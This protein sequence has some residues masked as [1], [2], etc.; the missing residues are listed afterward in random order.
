MRN[1]PVQCVT[2]R[3]LKT[4]RNLLSGPRRRLPSRTGSLV[5]LLVE[6]LEHRLTPSNIITTIAGNGSGG[7]SGD[8]GS[9]TA[10]M[11]YIPFGVAVDGSGNVFIADTYN[12]RIREVVKATGIIS[13]LAGTSS[14][15]YSGDGGPAIYAQLAYPHGVAVDSSGNVYI[16]DSFNDRIREIVKA[17]GNIITV[18]GNGSIGSGGDGGPATSAQLNYPFAA[19]VDASGNL[20]FADQGNNRIRE[21][22]KATGIIT[23]I[24]GNGTSGYSGDGGPATAAMLNQPTGVAVDSSGNVYIAD[25]HNNRIRE[26]VKATGIISTIAGTGTAGSSGDGGPATSAQLN[27]PNGV[28]VDG[29]GNVFIGDSSNNRIREVVKATGTLITFAGNGTVGFSGDGGPATS[30]Q[31]NYPN[32]VAVDSSGNVYFTDTY[33]YRIREVLG[34]SSPYLGTLSATAWTVNQPGYSGTISITGGT[35]PYS[36]LTATGLPTGLTASLAGATIT[37]SGTPTATGIFNNINISIQDSTGASA[38]RTFSITINAAPALGALTPTQWT[39]GVSGYTGAIPISGGTGPLT[40]SAQANL[41]TGLTATVTGTNVT[42]SGT[43]TTVG[44]YNNVQ[45]TVRDATGVTASG[46]YSITINTP[47][48]GSIITFAGTGTSGYNGDGGPATA[49]TLYYPWSVAVDGSGN[50]FI[51]DFYNSRVRE[52]VKATGN[53]IT[54]AGNGSVGYSGDG[55][56][57]TA[58]KLYYPSGVAVDAS[59]NVYIADLYNNRIREVVKATGVIITIAGSGSTTD[60]GDG[61]PATAAGIASPRGV[62]VDGSGNVFIADTSGNRI[63]EVVKATGIIMTIAGTGTTGYSGDGGPATAAL[64]NYPNG[65]AV[66]ASGNIFI[67]DSNNERLREIVQATG[68]IITVAGNGSVGYGGDGGPATAAKLYNPYSV[69]VDASGNLF[70]ADAY[71]YRIREVVQA[72]GNITT[73]AG[74]GTAGFGGDGGPAT[75]AKLY[76]DYGVA[77][78]GS[79]N[80]FI[81]DAYNN[82]VREVVGNSSP[83]L[84]SLSSTVWTVNQA[85]FSGT[86]GITNG[87]SPYS[88]LIASNLPPGLTASLSG[89]TIT[90]SGTPTATG[91]FSNI[92]ISIQDANGNSGSRTFTITINAAPA[93]GTLTPTQWTVGQ[94]GY[95]GAIPI[96]G[97]TGPLTVS[98]QA[99]LPP[100]L[101]A[102]VS[103]ANVTF[104][105]TPT[106]AGTYSNLQLTVKDAAGATST[107]TFSITVNGAPTL[108]SLSSAAWTV[109]QAGFTGTIAITGGTGPFG[110]LTATGLPPG[111]SAALGGSTITLSGKPTA[112]GTF[113]GITASVKDS[114]GATTSRTFTITINAA[115]ALGA[116]SPTVW[117]VNQPGYSGAIPVS[118]GTGPL[119]VSAQANLPPGLAATVTGTSVTFTGTPTTAGTYSNVQLTVKDAA[120][121]TASG[122]FAITINAVPPITTVAGNG[123]SGYGGDG[124]PATAAQLYGPSGVGVDGSGNLFIADSSNNVIREVVKATGTILT[125][126]GTGT[127]GY[128]GDGGPATAA[129]LYSPSGVAVDG[130]GNVFIADSGN[131]VI[132]EVVKATGTII[133]VAGSGTSGYSGDGGPATAALLN[134]PSG[135]ALDG[136]GNLFIADSSNNV[137]REVVKATG[138]ISTVAGTGTAG[139]GGDGGPATAALLSTPSGVAVDGSGNLFIAD[140]SNYRIREVVQATGN[141]VTVAGT[142]SAGDGGDGGPATAAMLNAPNRVTVDGSGNLFIADTLNN[143][144]REVVKATGNILTAAGN[145]TQGYGGDGGPATAAQLSTPSGLTVD[146]SGNLF[147][148]DQGN[149]RIREVLGNPTP[150]LGSLSPT[151]WTVNQ[152]GFTGT[153]SISGG[154]APY[155]NLTATGLPPG[156]TASL[157]GT[158]ITLS[159]TPTAAGTF[160]AINVAVQDATGAIANAGFSITINPALALGTLAPA[161]WTVGQPGYPGAIPVSGGTGPLTLS[162]QANLPPGLTATLTGTTVT[163]TGTPTTAGTYSNVQLTVKDATG[164]TASGTFTI[165]INAPV[166]NITTIAGNGSQGYSGDNGPATSAMLYHPFGVAVDASGNV[167]FADQSNNRVREVVKATGTIITVA[168]T[169]TAGFSGDGGPATAA[170]LNTPYG[171]AVDASGNLFIADG[172]NN[173]IRE[174]VKATGTIITVAGSGAGGYGGDGGPATSAMLFDAFGVAVDG[175]GNIFIA[176]YANERIREVVQATGIIITIAGNGTQGYGGDGGPA[177]SAMLSGPFGLAVDASGNVFFTDTYNQRIREVVKATGTIVTVAG[178]GTSGYGGDGGPATAAKLAYPEG[179]ALDG[180]GNLFIS[181]GNNH[182]IREVAQATGTITTIAGTGTAGFSGDGGP[183]TSAQLYFPKGVAVDGSGNIFI[184]DQSNNRIRE[185]LSGSSGMP[186]ANPPPR[187]PPGFGGTPGTLGD[188]GMQPTG[189]EAV[190]PSDVRQAMLP[191]VGQTDATAEGFGRFVVS[192]P[193]SA[194]GFAGSRPAGRID[195]TTLGM[196]PLGPADLDGAAHRADLVGDESALEMALLGMASQDAV[197]ADWKALSI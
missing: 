48:P 176:D 57:A 49:A 89:N 192:T 78:D 114:T 120:G 179:L 70:I 91:T 8:G 83:V 193:G 195:L 71:N 17:T 166:P 136:S 122:T 139:Y 194:S 134:A 94:S 130:S 154:L 33:N 10:A 92:N 4:V 15:G 60:S 73:V 162:A 59:G 20:F 75:A 69:V 24:A 97:G 163:F 14:G 172:Y 88:N 173:R 41:P 135:V 175:S 43:P 156:L 19:A 50:V 90:L 26:V 109:N 123:T 180:S 147:I 197:F 155:G 34:S 86:I 35:A 164:A 40:V 55:G 2:K 170:M 105:G 167:F 53:I 107:G 127:A 132:R 151:A 126:A 112:A 96:S 3:W 52:V 183:A 46:T 124:G 45:L 64:L 67:A 145:G 188:A 121:A 13:T 168:G 102:T 196:D 7:Y 62:A 22:V 186:M 36:N 58:A 51:S 185:I 160:S 1:T 157:A 169:G 6:Q 65:V 152:A 165:T 29:S 149:N 161:Q 11:L 128:A 61:G 66:D 142:G 110:N 28:A 18:A 47:A 113:N 93:L 143:V 54:I 146:G 5:R 9:A 190:G 119:V 159:G 108:G 32:G 181:D 140:T 144:I 84:G 150:S 31:L 138:T 99:N 56:P 77:V 104:S 82:R 115:P 87:T 80:L 42:F 37:L 63:R 133:T 74:N 68:Q 81:A 177:T 72:T 131:S 141:I 100:G 191:A 39:V 95:T 79:G 21:V 116:L 189:V 171:V 101:S 38:S 158:T 25:W 106:T 174:V 182:R 76:G 178:T 12:H 103:G 117:Q 137:I 184:A 44:T 27:Y 148:A 187:Q 98:A 30:A 111:L 153:I 16:A 85:G 23:T 129:M 118:G 125:I